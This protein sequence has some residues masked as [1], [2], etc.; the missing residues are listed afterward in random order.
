MKVFLSAADQTIIVSSYGR[1][2]SELDALNLTNWIATSYFLTLSSFQPL[3]GKLSDIFGRKACLLWSYAI[4][5][6]GSLFCG[7]A[8]DINQL[9]A[10]RVSGARIISCNMLTYGQV[11]QG[12]GGGGMTTV[13]SILLSDIIPLKDR[14]VWQGLINI[15]YASGAGSG[16]PLGGVLADFVGWRWAFLGQ[17]P[18]C[19][20][21]FVAVAFALKL[22]TT[23]QKNWKTNLGRI[24]F[25]GAFVLVSAVFGLI[26]GLDRGSNKSWSLPISYGPLI[27]SVFLFPIFVLVEKYVAAEPFAPGHIIFERSLFSYYLCNFFS[28]GGW[29]AI[30]YYI[31]LFFQAVDGL[32]ATGAAVRLI[33]AILAGVSGSLFGGVVMK[34]TGKFYWLTVIAY[35]M[36]T[37][38][39]IVVLCF[40][41]L[42]THSTYGVAVGLVF[43]GFGNGIGVTSTLIGLS[44]SF[45]L[46]STSFC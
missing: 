31:P 11:F 29:L 20:L 15:I 9:V 40:I 44:M 34:K 30:L 38:G 43:C 18:L 5:G 25:L 39:A 41:G 12:I 33:P 32:G 14:G 46:S 27:A 23:E 22:P 19:L 6:L 28:F 2:G 10:A 3:Y 37:I 35:A 26:F 13:V 7:L 4:F 1:I 16:A 24:D 36:L 21:A 42:V 45:H 8:Q 17:A